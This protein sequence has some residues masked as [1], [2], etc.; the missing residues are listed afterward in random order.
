M[1]LNDYR[2]DMER[3]SRC[4]Y[5][6]WIPFDHVKSWRFAGGCPSIAFGRF[7]AYSAGG[8]LAVALSLLDGRSDYTDRVLDIVY[9]CQMDG[10]CDVSDKICRYNMEPLKAMRE[11][12]VKLVEDGQI[13]PQYMPIIDNL[14]KED[15]MMSKPKSERGKWADGLAVKDLTKEKADVVFHAGCRLCY[16]DDLQKIA[17]T[18]LNLLCDA[19]IDIGIMGRDETCCGGRAYDMG[20]WGEFIKYAENNIEAWT[21][22]GVKTVVT[23][24]SDC[25]F[26]FKRL[27][28]RR[29]LKAQSLRFC[30]PWNSLIGLSMRIR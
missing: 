1:A 27:Y 30:T 4:S 13:L 25:Y 7:H 9:R 16:D 18:A 8:R 19:G 10:L 15:N 11:L 6:K 28:P 14:R 21:T 24:C 3:C 23:S 20:Y 12:R 17:K 22:A 2:A 29:G 5:C 26:S